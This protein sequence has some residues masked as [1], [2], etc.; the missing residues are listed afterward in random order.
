MARVGTPAPTHHNGP[1]PDDRSAT[2]HRVGYPRWLWLVALAV[3][4]V[5]GAAVV[6]LVEVTGSDPHPVG[7]GAIERLIPA[8][9]D[10]VLQQATVGIDLAAGYEAGLSLNGVAIPPAQLDV[11]TGLH[12]V[13][14]R[15][16]EGK[17]LRSLEPG[18]NCVVATYWRTAT[19]PAES[20][21]RSWCFTV[22]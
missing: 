2:T 12:L 20:S 9:D 10:K 21:T 1:V 11:T 8:P 19:G 15:P 22:L 18:Q 16:G 7:S 5:V 13:E 6:G 14:F 4:L 17:I 3:V